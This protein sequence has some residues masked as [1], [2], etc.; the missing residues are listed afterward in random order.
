MTWGDVP[1]PEDGA[2]DE[3]LL[4][5]VV[6]VTDEWIVSVHSMIVNDRVC[7]TSVDD[8]PLSW[9]AAW[10][11]DKGGAAHLAAVLWD[12]DVDPEPV[13][14]KKVAGDRRNRL[15]QR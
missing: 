5:Y 2:W 1:L 8:Y 12:P 11:Y 14:Y 15:P 7:L 4:A 6:R 9:T 10:C 3:R 13:G